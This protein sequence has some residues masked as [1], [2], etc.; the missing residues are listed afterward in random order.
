MGQPI[1]ESQGRN[2]PWLPARALDSSRSHALLSASQLPSPWALPPKLAPFVC[3]YS[4][5][6]SVLTMTLCADWNRSLPHWPV[7]D[8]WGKSEPAHMAPEFK[9]APKA[10][11]RTELASWKS[12]CQSCHLSTSVC[13]GRGLSSQRLQTGAW[14]PWPS[15]AVARPSTSN[16]VI[17]SGREKPSQDGGNRT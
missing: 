6:C 5:V 17:W 4:P 8:R 16:A 2:I 15:K 11:T 10:S 12:F 7:K 9:P 3:C 1:G 13:R 14:S